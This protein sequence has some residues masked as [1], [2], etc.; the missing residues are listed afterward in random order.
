MAFFFK[1]SV[2]H[3]KREE[4]EQGLFKK[5]FAAAQCPRRGEELHTSVVLLALSLSSLKTSPL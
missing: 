2:K 3:Y 5:L 1:L 4:K